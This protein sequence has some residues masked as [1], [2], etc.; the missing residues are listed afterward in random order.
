M[1]PKCFPSKAIDT[2]IVETSD[3]DNSEWQEAASEILLVFYAAGLLPGEINIE[4]SN[5]AK[6]IHNSS[7]IL[8]DDQQ[9]LSA[10]REIEPRVYEIVRNEL[11]AIWTSIAYHMRGSSDDESEM[12]PTV[13]ITCKPGARHHFEKTE[14]S[15]MAVIH[16]EK[17][18]QF[19]LQVEFIPGS[20]ELVAP[21]SFN[22]DSIPRPNFALKDK[23]INGASIGVQSSQ[24]VAGTLGGWVTLKSTENPNHYLKCALT[25]Y[26][27]IRAGD[28]AN[29][30]NNDR[31]GIGLGSQKPI[32]PINVVW[33]S[34][35]D[36]NATKAEVQKIIEGPRS[37]PK[38]RQRDRK[39]LELVDKISAAGPI[40]YVG[41]ASG[42]RRT[43]ENERLDWALVVTPSTF[44][45]NR[46]PPS[47]AFDND[48][49]WGKC[50]TYKTDEDDFITGFGTMKMGD[51]V[52]KAGRS[53]ITS[54]QINRI[55]RRVYWDDQDDSY[56]TEVIGFARDFA[57][58]GD[59]GSMVINENMELVGILFGAERGSNSF[60]CGFV[61]PIQAI[62]DDLRREVKGDIFLP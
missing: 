3:I 18:Q 27:V 13:M 40:G 36:T 26:H 29:L 44:T 43:T 30:T 42:Y 14:A 10:I 20:V 49:P 52:F 39:Y 56:E 5:P 55:R 62:R 47:T 9:L 61:T 58:G 34:I 35:L 53:S 12:K 4:I 6:M 22:E 41:F 23:P 7:R 8:P 33:P 38:S 60:G 25:C 24:L 16:S 19:S 17:Y 37:T 59:S 57:F 50:L 31:Y 46:P 2:F 54:G 1:W 11:P 48:A 21:P 32:S 45:R 15:I 51:W 28:P